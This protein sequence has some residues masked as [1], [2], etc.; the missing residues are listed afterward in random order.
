MPVL[1]DF[2]VIQRDSDHENF[3]NPFTVGDTDGKLVLPFNTGGLHHAPA[4]L[5]FMVRGLTTSSA[6]VAI[7]SP[8]TGNNEIQIGRIQP[9]SDANIWR[10]E[11]FVIK[12]NIL[13]SG[14]SQANTL[15]IGRVD[16][17]SPGPGNLFDDF[18]IRDIVCFFHQEA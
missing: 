4:L 12:T 1:S 16:A 17:N 7:K 10:H 11:Q 9:I 14:S 5:S 18:D 15:I 2:T 6:R 8:T 3:D 13:N